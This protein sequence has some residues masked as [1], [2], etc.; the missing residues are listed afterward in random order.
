MAKLRAKGGP[1]PQGWGNGGACRWSFGGSRALSV[2]EASADPV[3]RPGIR[4][5]T[6]F[7]VDDSADGTPTDLRWSVKLTEADLGAHE[8]GHC[9]LKKAP[10]WT[11]P[12]D[13]DQEKHLPWADDAERETTGPF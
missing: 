10:S 3:F 6:L 8:E 7:H 9:G 12:Q 2:A 4:R 1:R 5:R 13:W 11:G